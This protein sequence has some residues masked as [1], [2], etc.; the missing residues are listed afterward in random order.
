[1]GLRILQRGD[2]GE[3]HGDNGLRRHGV[4]L[5]PG[6]RRDLE[7]AGWRTTLEYRENH[8]RSRNGTLLEVHPA[9]YAEGERPGRGADAASVQV[10]SAVAETADRAWAALRVQADLVGLRHGR[11]AANRAS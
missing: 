1:M 11:R 2:R 3:R 9:W 4:V 5:E 10:I 8:V 7:R 6:D